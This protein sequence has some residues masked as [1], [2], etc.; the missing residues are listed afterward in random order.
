[1]PGLLGFE[2][3]LLVASMIVALLILPSLFGPVEAQTVWP[4]GQ[5]GRLDVAFEFV[6]GT[7]RVSDPARLDNGVIV[8]RILRSTA[9]PFDEGGHNDDALTTGRM[10][11]FLVDAYEE[12]GDEAYLDMAAMLVEVFN[13]ARKNGIVYD[14]DDD[15]ALYTDFGKPGFTPE[16]GMVFWGFNGTHWVHPTVDQAVGALYGLWKYWNATGDPRIPGWI[17]LIADENIPD[18]SIVL[19]IILAEAAYQA[20]GDPEYRRTVDELLGQV[21]LW[22]RTQRPIPPYPACVTSHGAVYLYMA[23]DLG[24]PAE[25]IIEYTA[26]VA[27]P[28]VI[29]ALY[30]ETTGSLYYKV[31]LFPN[32]TTTFYNPRAQGCFRGT[33]APGGNEEVTGV[34]H[35]M[36]ALSWATLLYKLSQETGNQTLAAVA[37]RI[38]ERIV[39]EQITSPGPTDHPGITGAQLQRLPNRVPAHGLEPGNGGATP[40]LPREVQGPGRGPLV[41]PHRATA[42]HHGPRTRY[43]YHSTSHLAGAR[44][45]QGGDSLHY[46]RAG[47]LPRL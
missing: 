25:T 5:C 27:A 20:T 45:S 39:A 41:H 35:V 42:G 46:H 28:R 43:D 13:P 36:Y 7:A 31:L 15:P 11:A 4:G 6:W 44:P 32:G 23:I 3:R 22:A 26:R 40:S 17:R 19:A 21:D 1:M 33:E 38:V 29:A 12:T 37:D 9:L 30:N 18:A 34:I 14:T 10:I 24:Y 2:S 47:P 8:N 16:P